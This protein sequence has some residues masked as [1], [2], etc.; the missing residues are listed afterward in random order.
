MLRDI[1][2]R[3]LGQMVPLLLGFE[4]QNR[5][6]RL[7]IRRLDDRRQTR[8]KAANANARPAPESR[9]DSDRR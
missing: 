3:V 7:Q 5:R 9:L 2:R 4:D 6:A 1:E 8:D